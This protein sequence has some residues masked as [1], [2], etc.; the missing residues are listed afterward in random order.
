MDGNGQQRD[1]NSIA[2]AYKQIQSHGGPVGFRQ[3]AGGGSGGPA[4]YARDTSPGPEKAAAS[5]VWP[6]T[7]TLRK[8]GS[9]HHSSTIYNLML[10]FEIA[11]LLDSG[12]ERAS[13]SPLLSDLRRPQGLPGAG[14]GAGSH[15]EMAVDPTAARIAELLQTSNNAASGIR[16][17][18]GWWAEVFT[19]LEDSKRGLQCAPQEPHVPAP[20]PQPLCK[21]SV[22]HAWQIA[23]GSQ[24][25]VLRHIESGHAIEL[26]HQSNGWF[27][28][29]P[30]ARWDAMEFV[31]GSGPRNA[32][33]TQHASQGT[34]DA[35]DAM[36]ASDPRGT[37][38]SI[39]TASV[40]VFGNWSV[41]M[42]GSICEIKC[43]DST[44]LTLHVDKFVH[45]NSSSDPC[46]NLWQ[47][48]SAPDTVAEAAVAKSVA[49]AKAKIAAENSLPTAAD[50]AIR[51]AGMARFRTASGAT[52]LH[53][54][55]QANS[56]KIVARLA[57]N[58][59]G[60]PVD[61]QDDAGNTA[62]HLAVSGGNSNQKD[63]M[64]AWH[65]RSLLKAGADPSV[66]NNRK[67]TPVDLTR[68]SEA[69]PKTAKAF[70]TATRI[71]LS[72]WEGGQ[73]EK[74]KETGKGKGKAKAPLVAA[75][76]PATR[77]DAASSPAAGFVQVP[78][79]ARTIQSGLMR[80]CTLAVGFQTLN[81]QIFHCAEGA[82]T[83]DPSV[84][85]SHAVRQ[86]IALS[87]EFK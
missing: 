69:L 70:E 83:N 10:N 23:T 3:L 65:V 4:L 32:G 29:T 50:I 61:V 44:K 48:S 36:Q 40:L 31:S 2:V 42:A 75:T 15:V 27:R 49:E 53:L 78:P 64:R 62:L 30:N 79:Q 67:E 51:R 66:I 17:A 37:A 20:P 38:S 63:W 56:P 18:S 60:I 5:L 59:V 81:S 14:A 68:A 28:T 84:D 11:P 33:N 25:S 45:A 74:E 87:R 24:T 21:T 12:A 34:A 85:L 7:E 80:G 55:V 1:R 52:L 6:V 9:S 76:L 73:K 72:R 13:A 43:L 71:V 39:A 82:V 47:L 58:N 8:G 77:F 26:V 86:Y 16:L 57:S 22:G 35:Y 46:G 19:L 41:R 54:A